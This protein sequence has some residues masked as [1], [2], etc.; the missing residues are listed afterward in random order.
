[1]ARDIFWSPRMAYVIS[2]VVVCDE[3]FRFVPFYFGVSHVH[4]F[5]NMR[6]STGPVD[7][8]LASNAVSL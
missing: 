5:Q 1:M 8:W 3:C 7:G 2:V 4:M 6:N